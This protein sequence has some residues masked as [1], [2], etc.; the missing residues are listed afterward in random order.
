MSLGCFQNYPKKWGTHVLRVLSEIAKK[1]WGTHDLR[2]LSK[3]A[4][5]LSPKLNVKFKQKHD[6]AQTGSGRLLP[7]ASLRVLGGPWSLLLVCF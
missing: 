4:I 6:L 3:I 5:I 7:E 1:R 2:V